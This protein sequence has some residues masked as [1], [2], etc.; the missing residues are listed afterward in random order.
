[1]AEF[2]F[3]LGGVTYELP[4]PFKLA[5]LRIIDPELN[6]IFEM[7]R[8]E[9][10][11]PEKYFESAS[12]ILLTVISSVK[13]DFTIDKLNETPMTNADI[14]EAIKTIAQASG[15]WKAAPKGEAEGVQAP[16]QNP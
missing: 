1:M 5:Q 13:P 14:I 10:K 2:K 16:L 12:K 6:K 8:Q 11:D 15:L 3:V 4:S 9:N 7:M